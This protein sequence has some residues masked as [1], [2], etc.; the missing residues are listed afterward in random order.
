MA[1]MRESFSAVGEK[2]KEHLTDEQKTQLDEVMAG[3]FGGGNS[4]NNN[5]RRGGRSSSRRGSP[6]PA[7]RI[8]EAV[9]AL[10]IEDEDERSAVAEIIKSVVEAQKATRDHGRD[11]RSGLDKLRKDGEESAVKSAIKKRRIKTRSLD[12]KLRTLRSE[13]REVVT[14]KQELEL[15][16]RDILD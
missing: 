15:I 6:D 14:F 9:A 4:N 12:K 8:K 2:I 1:K 5:A 11:S 16:L 10:G 7:R 3:R 13:L